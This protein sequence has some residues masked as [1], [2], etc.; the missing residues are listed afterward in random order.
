M[1]NNSVNHP[2]ATTTTARPVTSIP[3]TSEIPDN[4]GWNLLNFCIF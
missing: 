1:T 2:E 4:S 3:P